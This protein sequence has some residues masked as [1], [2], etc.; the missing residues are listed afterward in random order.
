M[1]A[2]NAWEVGSWGRQTTKGWVCLGMLMFYSR[3]LS[4]HVGGSRHERGKGGEALAS[5]DPGFTLF[6]GDVG[7]ALG[8]HVVGG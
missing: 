6:Q 4:Q 8:L 7:V 2:V 1:K 3:G 5:R